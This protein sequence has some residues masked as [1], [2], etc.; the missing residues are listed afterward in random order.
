MREI[1]FR[2]WDKVDK[3]WIKGFDI[4]NEGNIWHNHCGHPDAVVVQYT[5][6]K[7]KAGVEI[8][9]GDIVKVIYY[10]GI[11][12]ILEIRF[13][14][15]SV[16]FDSDCVCG[17]LANGF[18]FRW[19]SGGRDFLGTPYMEHL[20]KEWCEHYLGEHVAWE[21]EFEVIGNVWENPELL[22]GGKL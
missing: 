19:I 22:E 9:E 11:N 17:A 13:G 1:K 7:D 12:C 8:Y 2:A 20:G 15:H 6:L 14:L 3:Y 4:D 21:D 18:H 10:N 16:G 5:G